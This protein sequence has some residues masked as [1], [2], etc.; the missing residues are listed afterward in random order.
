MKSGATGKRAKIRKASIKLLKLL[1]LYSTA[2][3]TIRSFDLRKKSFDLRKEL[4]CWEKKGRPLP[5][6]HLYKQKTVKEYAKAFSITT[7][8]ETGTYKGDMIEATKKIFNKI[9]SIELN[10][11][12]YKSA[13]QMFSRFKNVTII[14]GDSGEVLP[15]LLKTI[16]SPCLF[17]LDAHYS[18]G[19]TA[20]G[21]LETPIMQ[22]LQH[23]LNHSIKKHVILIDD[24][25]CFVGQND[26]PTIEEL[27]K[28]VSSINPNLVF[29]IGNDI[30]RIH[31]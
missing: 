28:S 15:E 6:P 1:R 31:E 5:P 2:K 9:Y 30:I 13:R 21:E 27:K 11:A 18:G 16:K 25:R 29:R 12:L 8:I 17:W 20:K 10:M 22:E 23:I 19:V 24:A 7:F 4:F 3:T 26:Y 14:R